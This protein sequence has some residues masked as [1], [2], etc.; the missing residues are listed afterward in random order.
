MP[1]ADLMAAFLLAA[2]I[3]AAMPGP[4]M[5]Y[6]AARTLAGGRAAGLM[7]TLGIHLGGWVHVVAASLGLSAV[8]HAVPALFL[9][10][11]LAGAAYLVWLGIQMLRVRET[12]AGTPSLPRRSPAAAFR[13]SVAVEVLNPKTALFFLAF[14]PQFVDPSAGLPL[15]AQ[16]LILGAIVNAMFTAADLVAVIAAAAVAR[17]LARSAR[18]QV[19]LHRAGGA[20]LVALGLRLVTDRG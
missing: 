16:F 7:A 3:F 2:L 12:G 15:W 10:V 6:A 18:V 1:N 13:Q 17:G 4:A 8:F 19:W 9:A 14:L 20:I 11:K 5:M